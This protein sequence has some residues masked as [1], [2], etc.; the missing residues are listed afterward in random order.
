MPSRANFSATGQG[1]IGDEEAFDSGICRAVDEHHRFFDRTGFFGVVDE[2]LIVVKAKPHPADDDDIGIGL[3]GDPHQ[4]GVIGLSRNGKD[5]DFL[6]FDEAIE[7][8]DHRD[9]GPDQFAGN[10]PPR[11]IEG[12][13]SDVDLIAR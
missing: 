7:D 10:D 2:G 3:V 5:R 13:L 11:R 9:V 12:G 1:H 6:R 8:I 4:E